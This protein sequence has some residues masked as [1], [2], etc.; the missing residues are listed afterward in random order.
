MSNARFRRFGLCTT[1]ALA[2]AVALFVACPAAAQKPPAPRVAGPTY[3]R[4]IVIDLAGSKIDVKPKVSLVEPGGMVTFV[5][6][7]LASG[8]TVEI[9]YRVENVVDEKTG[10][11]MPWK[12]P[13]S[14]PGD[15]RG[16]YTFSANGEVKLTYQEDLGEGVW[17]YDVVLRDGKKDV[18]AIDPMTV[19]KGG[20]G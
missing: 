6:K 14:T 8:Q 18:R 12:G 2:A 19:G 13:Y 4:E 5:V 11:V 7:N 15:V 3:T 1:I 17:K 10:T 20:G 9:D 16:R